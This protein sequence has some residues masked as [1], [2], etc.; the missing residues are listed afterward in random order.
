MFLKQGA[1]IGLTAPVIVGLG[2]VWQ[3]QKSFAT[4]D[5][6]LAIVETKLDIK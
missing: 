6:R 3:I 5:R 2:F 1:E 4:I